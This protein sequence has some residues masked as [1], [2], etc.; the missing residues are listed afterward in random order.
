MEA[1]EITAARPTGVRSPARRRVRVP[2]GR[3]VIGALL[4]VAAAA[5]VLMSHRSASQPTLH[6]YLVPSRDLP[7]GHLISADDLGAVGLDLPDG[8]GVVPSEAA[9]EAIGRV[10]RHDLAALDLLRPGDLLERGRFGAPGQIEV[11]VELPA[12][13]ALSGTV[14]AGDQVDV[15]VTDPSAT[16][17][18]TLTRAT[19]VWVGDDDHAG[20]G[21]TSNTRLRLAVPDR[22]TAEVLVDAAVRADLTLV[23]PAPGAERPAS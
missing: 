15:L 19:V 14:G 21:A 22:E 6:R 1:S 20:I 10:L 13:R 2:S 18:T 16:G 12:A 7:A 11:S 17:T 8:L 3:A 5:G 23:L 4:V 9:D